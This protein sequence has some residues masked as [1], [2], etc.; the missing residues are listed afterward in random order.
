MSLKF[1]SIDVTV[2]VEGFMKERILCVFN[3]VDRQTIEYRFV[4]ELINK[5]TKPTV[6]AKYQKRIDRLWFYAM[7]PVSY[8][9]LTLPTN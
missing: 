8:T 4:D 1:R 9:H 5:R 6:S 3:T 2:D 7:R